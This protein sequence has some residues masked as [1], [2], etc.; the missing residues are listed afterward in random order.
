MDYE[1][2]RAT[3]EDYEALIDFATM[4]FYVDF[5]YRLKKLYDGHPEVA[6][7]HLLVTEKDRIKALIGSFPMKLRVGENRLNLR[8]IGTVSVH[9]GCR[10]KGY[11]KLLLKQL[12]EEAEADG[13]DLVYL[14]GQR[15]RY[16]YFGFGQAATQLGF[17]V[18]P[19]NRRHCKAVS[20][21]EISL[22]PLDEN[23]EYLAACKALSD[24]Q[25]VSMEREISAFGEILHT[26]DSSGWVILKNGKFLGYASVSDR[27]ESVQEL[28]LSDYGTALPV[29]FALVEHCGKSVIFFPAWEQTELIRSLNEVAEESCIRT[30]EMIDV[31]NYP[32][33]IE[34]Y[35][36]LKAESCGLISGKY[37]IDVK[38]KGRFAIRVEGKAV[39][40][41][42]TEE[43]ADVSLSHLQM[44]SYL[45][46]PV[47]TALYRTTIER[48]WFPIPV[49]L[50]PADMV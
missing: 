32:N 19:T 33:V 13:T 35:L 47:S 25:S 17:T 42:E 7:C 16:G 5:P 36:R 43:P 1:I 34:A 2:R 26:W 3:S 46:S 39:T 49:I 18:T 45:F 29:I 41:S 11:M 31:L 28:V 50:P 40:V 12:V 20:T 6:P 4:V 10:G 38:E 44:M 23:G 27:G 8:G 9:P 24:K 14:G 48:S 15:Q 21:K 37:V 30:G 22:L